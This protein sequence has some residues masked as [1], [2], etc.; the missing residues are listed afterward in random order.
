MFTLLSNIFLGPL[1]RAKREQER[2]TERKRENERVGVKQRELALFTGGRRAHENPMFAHVFPAIKIVKKSIERS[3]T[4]CDIRMHSRETQEREG[5]RERKESVR[6]GSTGSA[7]NIANR[8][9][10]K[11]NYQR[12]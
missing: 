5:E 8:K 6:P 4:E 10:G 2:G 9:H 1:K 11:N 12:L 7:R 3:R